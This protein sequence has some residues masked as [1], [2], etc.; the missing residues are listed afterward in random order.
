MQMVSVSS[1]ERDERRSLP[2]ALAFASLWASM[3]PSE[4]LLCLLLE[5]VEASDSSPSVT[6]TE[7][8]RRRERGGG[9][10]SSTSVAAAEARRRPALLSS[11][12][13]CSSRL[14]ERDGSS[15]SVSPPR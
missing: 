15:A 12:K 11:S 1:T 4:S 6:A 8:A 2:E 14:L 13:G 7:G 5:R 3:S 9:P 10:A